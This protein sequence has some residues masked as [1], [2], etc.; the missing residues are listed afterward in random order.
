GEATDFGLQPCLHL[1]VVDVLQ[2]VVAAGEDVG[3]HALQLDQVFLAHSG[4]FYLPVRVQSTSAL[5][6]AGWQRGQK[7]ASIPRTPALRTFEPERG[8]TSRS[9]T[10]GRRGTST[11]LARST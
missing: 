1:V 7:Y 10:L 6:R 3:E 4:G 8:H 9:R 11:R 5:R 2:L